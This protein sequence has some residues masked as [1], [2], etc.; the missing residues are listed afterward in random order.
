MR[1]A[2]ILSIVFS[3]VSL[4]LTS[5]GSGQMSGPTQSPRPPDMPG[6]LSGKLV[7]APLLHETKRRPPLAGALVVLCQQKTSAN[8]CIVNKRLSSKS[9]DQN[10]FAFASVPPGDYVVLYNPF[11]ITDTSA[12]WKHWDGRRLDFKDFNTLNLSMLPDGSGKVEISPGPSGGIS[13]GRSADG[14]PVPSGAT[15]GGNTA[16][17]FASHPLIVEFV[18]AQKPLTVSIVAGQTTQVTIY[19]HT[20]MP[21]D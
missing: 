16:V 21:Y 20:R 4:I 11:P 14:E 12:Y 8:Q 17:W 2:T 15:V 18:D 3:V 6:H 5:C 9:D 10:A 7:E 1:E 19:T 13:M